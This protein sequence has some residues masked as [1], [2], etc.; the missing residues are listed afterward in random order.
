MQSIES[1]FMNKSRYFFAFLFLCLLSSSIFISENKPAAAVSPVEN[2]WQTAVPLPEA[3]ID[4]RAGVV[5]GKIY[6]MKGSVNYEFD[7]ATNIWSHKT[8][9]PTP[10]SMF[11]LAVWQDK[12]YVISGAKGFNW[13]S[14]GSIMSD[15]VEVYDPSTD[16]WQTK[17]PIPTARTQ[18]QANAVNG[19]IYLVGG[20]NATGADVALNEV[21]NVA[22]DSWTTAEPATYSVVSYASAVCGDK[23]YIMGG[24]SKHVIGVNTNFLQIYDCAN[25]SWSLGAPI[26]TTVLFAAA[27]A[28]TGVVAPR[29]IYLM[30]GVTNGYD[31]V[32][33]V[34]V[35]DPQ[36]DVWLFGASMPSARNIH[37]VAVV[38]DR[39]YAIGGDPYCAPGAAYD[40]VGNRAWYTHNEVYTP[41]GYGTPDPAY[42]FEH[43]PP[44]VTLELSLNA[45]YTNST[46][47]LIFF[48]DKA[49][50]WM[51]YSLDGQPAVSIDGN[52]TIANV[53][54]GIHSL[55]IQV[56]DTFGN[57]A[58]SQTINFTVSVPA[59]FPVLVFVAVTATL[60]AVIAAISVVF[61]RRRRK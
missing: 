41:F 38:D 23:I 11:G 48:V 49:V 27:D 21:Y 31:V 51:G 9:M 47:P 25:N 30:G 18:M 29:R 8:R 39:L 60:A 20:R 12:I 52:I 37:A 58:E 16:T 15:A 26:P 61:Y 22:N 35:Y 6:V 2:T 3:V 5:D 45:T 46:V 42:V 44:N 55:A 56:N 57:Y 36:S 10:R 13:S 32:G 40:P 53:T 7:P 4:G 24:Q 17:Q 14:G 1:L 43:T 54:N 59:A 19:Q 34:Q 28:T 50:R 33:V